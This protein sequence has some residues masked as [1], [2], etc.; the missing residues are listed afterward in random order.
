MNIANR[1]KIASL[2]GL[3]AIIKTMAT[4]KDEGEVQE[5][6]CG[7]LRNLIINEGKYLMQLLLLKCM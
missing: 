4:H 1:P 3:T 7:A 5:N 6:A 2:G